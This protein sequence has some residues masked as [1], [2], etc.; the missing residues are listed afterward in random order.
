MECSQTLFIYLF[1]LAVATLEGIELE[2][3]GGGLGDGIR[4]EGG[5]T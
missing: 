3:V 5:S 1:G 2:C 4:R